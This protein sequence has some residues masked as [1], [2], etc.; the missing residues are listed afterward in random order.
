MNK[1]NYHSVQIRLEIVLFSKLE[2]VK[3]MALIKKLFTIFYWVTVVY[4]YKNFSDII[5]IFKYFQ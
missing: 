3:Y 2:R 5:V 4:K 1:K